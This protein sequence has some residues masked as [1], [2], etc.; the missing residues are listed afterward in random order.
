MRFKAKHTLEERCSE[1]QRVLTKYEDR[2]PCI[3]E[4]GKCKYDID[5]EKYLVPN[6][7]TIG[8]FIWIIRK[9]IKMKAEE[10][11]FLSVDGCLINTNAFLLSVYH[12]HKNIDGFLY[13][14]YHSE[15]CFGLNKFKYKKFF[16]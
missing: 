16:S 6:N 11:L 5:K 9:R 7:L 14:D 13:I 12:T 10:A 2:I 15:N 3:V 1:S 4:K 8:Q